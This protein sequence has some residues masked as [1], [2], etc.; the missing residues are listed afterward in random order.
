M[1][2]GCQ[3]PPPGTPWAFRA[4]LAQGP[5]QRALWLHAANS[6]GLGAEP[7]G[8][9]K[10]IAARHNAAV[11]KNNSSTDFLPALFARPWRTSTTSCWARRT[12]PGPSAS[13]AVA[14]TAYAPPGCATVM[15]LRRPA[16]VETAT[17]PGPPRF[18]ISSRSF[19]RSRVHRTINL[20]PMR[21]SGF[22]TSN[23]RDPRWKPT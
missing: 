3:G 7:P 9:G 14:S 21:W 1:P 13:A 4:V 19:C 22:W 15:D 18:W 5:G 2:K 11:K 8:L 20:S 10:R 16:A 17:S 23:E 12:R 6:G